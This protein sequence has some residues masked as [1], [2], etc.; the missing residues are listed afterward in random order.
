M[1]DSQG[2]AIAAFQQ[3]AMEKVASDSPV[4]PAGTCRGSAQSGGSGAGEGS[5][6]LAKAL[7]RN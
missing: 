3:D 4:C 6:G 2:A 1:Q 5:V 7:E